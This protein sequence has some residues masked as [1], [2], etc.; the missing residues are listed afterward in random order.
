MITNGETTLTKADILQWSNGVKAEGMD[1]G[2]LYLLKERG[3]PMLGTVY[4]RLDP[5]YEWTQ[6]HFIQHNSYVVKWTLK[7]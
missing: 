7:K 3:A 2:I 5:D 6:A 1:S 4:P